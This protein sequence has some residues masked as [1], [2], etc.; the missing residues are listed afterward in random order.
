[1]LWAQREKRTRKTVFV[2]FGLI[3]AGSAI[4]LI[5]LGFAW[6]LSIMIL[7]LFLGC[8]TL[9]G[10]L[11]GLI[12]PTKIAVLGKQSRKRV[13]LQYSGLLVLILVGLGVIAAVGM[14]DEEIDER[15]LF[16]EYNGER[17]GELRH[18]EG[19]EIGEILWIDVIY[20]G[21][22]KDGARDGYGKYVDRKGN[23]YQGQ[24]KNDSP[25]GEGEMILT[26]GEK[27][28]GEVNGWMRHGYG[29]ATLKD[30]TV[31]EGEWVEDELIE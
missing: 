1:M 28:V 18:G 11:I 30:G 9:I 22:Y 12:A 15:V 13:L 10:M 7:F 23:I 27:Y 14:A 3:I 29:K 8:I 25:Y 5:G 31:M 20:E 4:L 6:I 21:E 2:C 24:W 17:Q 19:T 16:G 26:N